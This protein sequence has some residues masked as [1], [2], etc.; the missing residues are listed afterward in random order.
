MFQNEL[1]ELD[2]TE[3]AREIAVALSMLNKNGRENDSFG[4]KSF[5]ANFAY[6]D[7]EESGFDFGETNI[8]EGINGKSDVI[9]FALQISNCFKNLYN[10]S[11]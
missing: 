10:K 4:S 1:D 8:H 9:I 11:K 5:S 6:S 7:E 3:R 2:H